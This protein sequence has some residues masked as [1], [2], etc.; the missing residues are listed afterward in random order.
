MMG[1]KD[2]GS[3]KSDIGGY[4][5]PPSSEMNAVLNRFNKQKSFGSPQDSYGETRSDVGGSSPAFLAK[6]KLRD[7]GGTIKHDERRIQSGSPYEDSEASFEDGPSQFDDDEFDYGDEESYYSDGEIEWMRQ[8]G[9]EESGAEF[10][11]DSSD[12][13]KP[14]LMTYREMRELELKAER[15]R[16]EAHEKAKKQPERDVAANGSPDGER[17]ERV[18]RKHC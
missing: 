2:Y 14:K 13:T 8:Q 7:T 11:A 10:S 1:K 9:E 4:G 5:R 6:V 3:A 15:E 12:E 16:K 18:D 17:K